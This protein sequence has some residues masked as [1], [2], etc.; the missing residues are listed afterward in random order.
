MK[1]TTIKHFIS[2][3]GTTTDYTTYSTGSTSI[4]LLNVWKNNSRV[5]PDGSNS[6]TVDTS[7]GTITFAAAQESTDRIVLDFTN[8]TCIKEGHDINMQCTGASLDQVSNVNVPPIPTALTPQTVDQMGLKNQPIKLSGIIELNKTIINA[9][10]TSTTGWTT[11]NGTLSVL[12]AQTINGTRNNSALKFSALAGASDSV[13]SNE[14]ASTDFTNQ[15]YL[16]F[17]CLT[18]DASMSHYVKFLYDATWQTAVS[19]D[20]QLRDDTWVKVYIPI[21]DLLSIILR[22]DIKGIRFH[23]PHADITGGEIIDVKD[24]EIVGPY[25]YDIN[26]IYLK[27][28][29]QVQ[30]SMYELYDEELALGEDQGMLRC[31]MTNFTLKKSNQ[32]DPQNITLTYS[33]NFVRSGA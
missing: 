9:S 18:S 23:V 26:P 29:S 24:I 17:W 14:F 15:S 2:K 3:R 31:V 27:E 4:T 30:N 25:E 19:F 21:S 10:T 5:D 1:N 13:F 33:A 22:D 12:S 8:S 11:V 7:A 6:Y 32:E 20:S 16:T 28:M